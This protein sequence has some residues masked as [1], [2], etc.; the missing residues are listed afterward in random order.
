MSAHILSEALR[1]ITDNLNRYSVGIEDA[2]DL[3]ADLA[4][5]LDRA[6]TNG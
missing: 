6:S 1:R 2:E 3:I 5:T 4:Q